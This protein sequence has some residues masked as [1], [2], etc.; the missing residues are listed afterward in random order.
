MTG[1]TDSLQDI[2]L[3]DEL[4]DMRTFI[5]KIHPL[6]K[7]IVTLFYLVIVI[8][9]SKYETSGVLPLVLFPVVLISLAE[10][11]ILP[12]LK[13]VLIIMPLIIG[14]SLFNPILDQRPMLIW[15]H[16]TI[17][18]GW[19]SFTSILIKSLLTIISSLILIATTGMTNLGIALRMIK[20][21]KIIVLQLLLTYRYIEVLMEEV[22]LITNAYTLRAPRAK[23]I[24]FKDLGSLLGQL[25]LRTIERGQNVYY[26]M[27]CRGFTG[28]YHSGNIPKFGYSDLAYILLWVF[29]FLL[30]RN[31]NLSKLIGITLTGAK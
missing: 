18:Y 10:L 1:I 29:F 5:H 11:P 27:C 19:I 9:F 31:I 26:A 2:R 17:T 8:S 15:G 20:I 21:P 6:S 13:R 22:I 4:G 16:I 23:G 7:L 28:E 24:Q 14:I 12:I 25:L 3:L 30:A